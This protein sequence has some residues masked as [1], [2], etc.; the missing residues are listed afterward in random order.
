MEKKK[1]LVT[2]ATGMVGRSLRHIVENGKSD[3][4]FYWIGSRD[5]NLTNWEECEE[6]FRDINPN[7]VIHL[8]SRVGGLYDN[9]KYNYQYFMTNN[10]I[11]LN[12]I[13]ACEEFGV[14][15]LV[16]VLST[17][18]YG[19]NI[20]IS[21]ENIHDVPPH[22]SNRGY[23]YS[24][25]ILDIGTDLL[26]NSCNVE[27][28]NVIPT[29]LYG[30]YDNYDESN[31]HVVAA[32]IKRFYNAKKENLQSVEI[33][34]NGLALRQFLNAF[35]LAKILL[36]LVDFNMNNEKFKRVIVSSHHEIRICDLVDMISEVV[37]YNGK[38]VYNL[39]YPNGQMRKYAPMDNSLSQFPFVSLSD[40]IRDV[41]D[42]WDL[43]G[44]SN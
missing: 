7:I 41:I 44:Q 34:G 15:R 5:C 12:I 30:I 29:N 40:G 27:C 14:K 37:G 23:A 28:I 4:Y 17:C 39:E 16:S 10:R 19:D 26:A 20:D 31:S 13:R 6:L 33:Y 25:R 2:G 22:A 32:L 35:D 1:I 18:I 3:A 36:D 9:M 8:A 11:N 24:K 42:Y 43:Y 21:T 38:I